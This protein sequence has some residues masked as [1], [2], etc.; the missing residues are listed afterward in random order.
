M[1]KRWWNGGSSIMSYQYSHPRI[2]CC[3][4]Y[5]LLW[6]IY[7]TATTRYLEMA[8]TI[9]SSPYWRNIICFIWD[10]KI[11]LKVI[12]MR[13]QE[14]RRIIPISKLFSLLC[15]LNQFWPRMDNGSITL[16]K[17]YSICYLATAFAKGFIF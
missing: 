13:E 10:W 3:I 17:F 2:V 11:T 1:L 12:T 16:P 4:I 15:A 14:K 8:D 6:C 5:P 7:L 9:I